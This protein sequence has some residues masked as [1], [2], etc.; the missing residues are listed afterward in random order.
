M[1]RWVNFLGPY[2]GVRQICH[3]ILEHLKLSFDS[4]DT[5]N[6]LSQPLLPL[7]CWWYKNVCKT[8]SSRESNVAVEKPRRLLHHTLYL[9]SCLLFTVAR[10]IGLL[11]VAFP[12]PCDCCS[13][14]RH[15]PLLLSRS[16][17]T[18]PYHYWR[19]LS[20]PLHYVQVQHVQPV[21]GF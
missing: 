14:L 6:K 5:T 9:Y 18:I 19:P 7:C 4:I 11:H 3:W 20:D 21:E 2:V 13:L 12:S 1:Q 15:R 10:F 17:Q 8:A 16:R